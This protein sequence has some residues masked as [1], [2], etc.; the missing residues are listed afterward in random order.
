MSTHNIC[1]CQ[2]I[3]KTFNTLWLKKF[4]YL[5]KKNIRPNEK[6]MFTV[7]L[8]YLIFIM[9]PSNFLGSPRESIESPLWLSIHH[10]FVFMLPKGRAIVQTSVG[11][12]ITLLSG[13]YL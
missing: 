1:F 10:T 2:E 7:I 11:P 12:S 4:L 8:S 5:E 13:A 9:K 6:N 3:K